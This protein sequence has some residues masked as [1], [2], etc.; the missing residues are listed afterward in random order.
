MHYTTRIGD[1]LTSVRRATFGLASVM[2]LAACERHEPGTV[3]D[4]PARS[5]VKPSLSQPAAEFHVSPAGSPTGDGSADRPWDLATALG[6]SVGVPPGSTIWLHDGIYRNGTFH[7]GYWSNLHGTYGAPILVRQYPGARVTVTNFLYVAGAHAWFW[8]FE[9]VNTEPQGGYVLGVNVRGPGTRLIHLV[10]HDASASGVYIGN[11]A[12]DAEVYGSLAYNNGRSDNLD[13]GIYCQNQTGTLLQQNVIF[14]NWAYGIHC[15]ASAVSGQEA[16]QHIQVRENVV[17]DNY[18]WGPSWG[19]DLLIGGTVPASGIVDGNYSYRSN[20]ANTM[21]ADIGYDQVMNQEIVFT[22]NYLVG[23]WSRLGA[24]T[25]AQV[26][27]NT[28]FNFTSGAMLASIG[29]AGGQTWG[30]NTFFGDPAA[31]TWRYGETVTSFDGWRALS[32]IADPGSYA[33]PAPTGMKVVVQPSRYEPGRANIVVYNW[34]H[35]SGVEVDPSG[36]LGLGDAYV[37]QHAQDFYG[38][39]IVSGTYAGGLVQL[40][41]VA[42]TPVGPAG[43]GTGPAPATGPTFN[44]FVLMKRPS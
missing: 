1:R 22:N 10:V 35:R 15:Y 4:A 29:N 17:F 37:I 14:N 7:G 5:T 40:P 13:H 6:G 33:G 39:P 21:T 25:T 32:G 31:A 34:E 2:L 30:N 28:L 19:A 42:V 43:A 23:G 26:T 16:L 41:A 8:G 20:A 9:V 27:G 44:A 12:A 18:V 36:V 11:E 24:W 3:L 38:P